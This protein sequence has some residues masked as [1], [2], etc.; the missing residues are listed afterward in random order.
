M[1]DGRVVVI[2]GVGG[3]VHLLTHSLTI[4]PDWTDGLSREKCF[5]WCKQISIRDGE[6]KEIYV[7]SQGISLCTLP[8]LPTYL[9][10]NVGTSILLV[11]FLFLY[12]FF[13]E[14]STLALKIFEPNPTS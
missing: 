7:Y 2:G 4:W 6:E 12:F 10:H 1:G 8:T 13:K 3:G 9:R 5:V 11:F 14:S